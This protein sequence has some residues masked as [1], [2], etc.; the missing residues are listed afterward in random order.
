M[1]YDDLTD[2]QK[3]HVDAMDKTLVS[4]A[5]ELE[6]LPQNFENSDH[7]REGI[8]VFL[9]SNPA[10]AGEYFAKHPDEAKEFYND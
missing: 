1:T 7:L 10:V 2:E 8:D 9:K 6:M 4:K 5:W 3:K